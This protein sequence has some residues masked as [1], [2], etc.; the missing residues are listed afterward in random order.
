MN[1]SI[2]ITTFKK[3]FDRVVKLVNFIRN[4]GN[5]PIIMAVNG[6]YKENFDQ[7]YRKHIL[8][9]CSSIEN[10]YVSMFPEFRSLSKLWNTILITSSTDW[11]LVINDDVIIMDN[12]PFYALENVAND[13]NN[14]E[15]FAINGSWSHYFINRKLVAEAGWFEERLLGIGEE[16]TDMVW[17]LEKLGK[18][19]FKPNIPSIGNFHDGNKPDNVK[20]GVMHY[21][22]YNR[23]FIFNEKYEKSE[24]GLKGMFEYKAKNKIN[25]I[26]SYPNEIFYWNNKHKLD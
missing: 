3:R 16:D 9:F 21:S 10:C 18:K 20:T 6:D 4:K 25:N 17:R 26:D 14:S 23:N 13:Q 22:H 1:F 19:I 24:D 2:G 12:F 11:N 8:N 7:E 5:W 15:V